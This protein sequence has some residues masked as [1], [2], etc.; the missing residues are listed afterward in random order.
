MTPT[1]ELDVDKSC[2]LGS[3]CG[4]ETQLVRVTSGK[5]EALH[6]DW[7]RSIAAISG[8]K[9]DYRIR[10]TG[11]EQRCEFLVKYS[12]L[13]PSPVSARGPAT[14]DADFYTGYIR[15]RETRSAIGPSRW[16]YAE[17]VERGLWEATCDDCEADARRT[18]RGSAFPPVP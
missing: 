13:G 5:I 16:V 9:S 3:F 15:V 17:R 12:R 1:F 18:F 14:S 10:A 6:D 2:D 7:G 4:R 11:K 8:L